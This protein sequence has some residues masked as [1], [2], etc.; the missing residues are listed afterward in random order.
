MIHIATA[1]TN[2]HRWVDI[3]LRY[4]ARHTHEPYRVHAALYGID[5]RY[6]SRF[7][8][9]VDETATG[10][11]ALKTGPTLNL[12]AERIARS[13]DPADLIV[14]THGDSFPIADWVPEARRMLSERSLAA[15]HRTE[16]LEPIPHESF[17][18]TTVGFW[19]EIG[20]EWSRGPRWESDGRMV[21]DTGAALWQKLER[22]GIPWEPVL[23]TNGHNLHPLWFAVY[24][25]V[26]YHHGA[27]FRAPMSRRDAAAFSRLPV[28]LRNLAGVR[29]RIANSVLSRRIYRRVARDE[30]FYME[31]TGPGFKPDARTRS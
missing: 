20:G 19:S 30:R 25:E 31:L 10:H 17:C 13:A 22:L 8:D 21:T 2:D 11:G 7:H 23:R 9:A 1:H 28:P 27:G 14:F 29:R 4:L 6:R 12:L 18:V 26:F 5:P 24:G 3:Q 15:V 16:N